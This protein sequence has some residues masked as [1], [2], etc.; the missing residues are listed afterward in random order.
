MADDPYAQP[1]VMVDCAVLG[2]DKELKLLLIKRALPP[3]EGRWALPGGYVHDTE[4]L[5]E[6]AERELLEE[7]GVKRVY[8]DQLYT[9]GDVDRFP[10]K[11]VISVAYYALVKL[12]DHRVRA[13]T[14]AKEAAWFAI[15]DI[16]K[17]AF[18]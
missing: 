3:F 4:S 15:G 2:F 13:A 9:F 11:R 17:L 6:A 12:S 1:G 16:P 7:T 14:D 10:G 18:D 5:D 8:L